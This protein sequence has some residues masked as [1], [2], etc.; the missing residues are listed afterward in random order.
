MLSTE[1]QP[2]LTRRRPLTRRRVTLAAASAAL[3]A[4]ACALPGQRSGE[5]PPASAEVVKVTFF[6]RT[7]EE[8]AFTK[9]VDAF[10]E[11][12]P[13]IRL[14][15]Q[16]LAGNYLEVIRTHAAAGTLA[17]VIYNQNLLFEALAV[18][19]SLQ[20][21]DKLVQRDK[22]NLKQWYE[23]GTG[24]LRLDG[25]LFGLPARG[26]VGY[27]FLF[28]NRDAFARAG[29]R[30]P[31][32]AWTL[33]DLV[34]A[35]EKLTVHDGSRFGYNTQWGNF[36][37]TLAAFRRFGG[38]LLSPDG[39]R[40]VADSPQALQAVQWHWD[41]WHRK[42]VMPAKA[43]ANADFGNGSVAMAGQ[44]LAG[45]RS[46][47]RDAVKD[48]FKWSMVAMPKGPTGKFGAELSVA[49]V[50]LNS[51]TRVLDEGWQVLQW[52]TDRESGVALGL[53]TRG[54]NTPG[55]RHDVYCDERLLNDPAYPREMLERVC[56]TMD[57]YAGTVTYSVAANFRQAEVDQVVVKHTNAFRENRTAPSAPALR[58][59]AAEV[60]AILD[61]PR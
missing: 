16:A 34:T 40:C 30:E 43:F 59:M 18:G 46:G 11:K 20:P 45:A 24:A 8:E 6:S 57:Q 37:H 13:R 47:L 60:Q 53:Q 3:A 51:K 32:D 14:D 52:F 55:M 1:S 39:K 2:R 31:H 58:V 26:Q 42:E 61:Q 21:I 22:L 35:A 12:H 33:D 5:Q 41:L 15:Y 49:P 25:K 19:G 28:F 17:D 38:D 27:C 9:R 54:S 10:H 56:K 48:G 7:A 36:Q 23:S 44:M 4:P 50:A 29:I